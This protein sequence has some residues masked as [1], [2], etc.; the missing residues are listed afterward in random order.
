M[1]KHGKHCENCFAFGYC[2]DKGTE[3]ERKPN[4][5]CGTYVMINNDEAQKLQSKID[6]QQEQIDFNKKIYRQ[7]ERALRSQIL[8]FKKENDHLKSTFHE[9][10]TEIKQLKTDLKKIADKEHFLNSLSLKNHNKTDLYT[11]LRLAV[12]RAKQSLEVADE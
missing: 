5:G 6:Q 3:N 7:Y 8:Q 4:K 10:R 11:E 12:F 9:Y 1:A 2:P